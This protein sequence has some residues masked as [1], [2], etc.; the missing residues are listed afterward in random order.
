MPK[1]FLSFRWRDLIAPVEPCARAMALGFACLVL[2]AIVASGVI[3]KPAH[4]QQQAVP[5]LA[6]SLPPV[7]QMALTEK[8]IQGMIAASKDVRAI[9]DN[10][11]EGIDK[12]TAKTVSLLDAAARKNGLASYQEYEDVSNNVGLVFGGYD[13]VTRKYVGKTALIKLRIARVQADKK[14]SAEG[15]KE[16]LEGLSD[17]LQLPLP[18]VENRNNIALVLKFADRLSA[19]MDGD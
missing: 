3:D 16:A 18:L 10:A 5:L 13:E 14:M 15:K 6:Q 7:K 12:L 8:Q 17:D 11:H 9:I 2:A 19:V 1:P 4:A